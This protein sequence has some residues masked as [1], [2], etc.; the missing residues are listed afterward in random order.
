MSELEREFAIWRVRHGLSRRR[1]ARRVTR[2]AAGALDDQ[3]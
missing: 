1:L 2:R 3:R